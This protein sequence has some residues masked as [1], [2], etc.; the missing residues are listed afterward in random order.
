MVNV[1]LALAT[2]ALMILSFPSVNWSLLAALALAPLLAALA[3]ESRHGRR[4]LLGYL[5]GTVYWFGACYWIQGV[6][7][8]HGGMGFW[9]SWGAFL[10][11]ALAKG[12]HMAVFALAAG[13]VI[14]R[15]YAIPAVA[16]IWVA[17][18]ATHGPLGFAWQTLGNAGINMSVPLRLAPY[19][20]VY[21][22]SFVFAMTGTALALVAL[23]RD[24]RELAWLLALFLL[25]LLPELPPAARGTERAVLI[26]PNLPET[27]RWTWQ[28]LAKARVEVGAL[29]LQTALR[30]DG[31][32]P[33]LMV[34]PEVPAPLSFDEDREFREQATRLAR[35]ARSSFLFGVIASAPDGGPLNSAMLL[36]PSGEYLGRY[37]KINLVPFGEYVPP[38]F[39]FVNAITR[40]AGDFRPGKE[41]KVFRADGRRIGAFI[42]YEAV[43]PHFVRRFAAGGAEVLV[44][45]SND[46]WFGRSAAR[47]QHLNI[48]RMRAV[49]NRRWLLRAT[50][51][52]VTAAID[53]AGRVMQR[54]APYERDALDALF[55]FEAEKTLYTRLGDWFALVCAAGGVVALAAARRR[56]AAESPAT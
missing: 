40:E 31:T 6:L 17:I 9:G 8:N 41:L 37:D 14:R 18:E 55:S 1:L 29:S 34:W 28:S 27:V 47:M 53:P 13:V 21:G 42:C 52:G 23:R 38:F 46:G 3:R 20:G 54:L 48:A 15:F 19:T 22:V 4:F 25:Y 26:Q 10:L 49:E 7:E 11:F 51:D 12:L 45:V 56:K 2:A 35:A 32:P 30:G 43:F 44:N 36:G 50:N 39:G 5:A 33:R 24:R 16:A